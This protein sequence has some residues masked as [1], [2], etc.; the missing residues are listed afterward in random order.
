MDKEFKAG[1]AISPPKENG[2]QLYNANGVI[3]LANR[4]CF[5]IYYGTKVYWYNGMVSSPTVGTEY[6]EWIRPGIL[7]SDGSEFYFY[8]SLL[9]R[10]DGPAVVLNDGSNYK[11]WYRYGNLH[12]D[13]GPAIKI[14]S[15]QEWWVDGKHHRVDGPATIHTDGY[16]DYWENNLMHRVDGPAQIYPGFQPGVSGTANYWYL[17]EHLKDEESLWLKVKDTPDAAKFLARK[18]GASE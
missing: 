8:E 6:F 15:S 7:H 14:T 4:E 11:A 12:R 5:E 9:H 16:V 17:G 1:P 3:L 13:D 18:L 10:E 2:W